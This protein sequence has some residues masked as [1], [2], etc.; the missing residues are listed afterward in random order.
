MSTTPGPPSEAASDPAARPAAGWFPDP[1]GGPALRWWDGERWTEHLSAMPPGGG[2]QKTSGFAIAALVFGI[3]GGPLF[4]LIF[5]FV[6]R[7]QIKDSEGKLG[8][9]GLATAGIVLGF[10]WI[11]IYA[12]ILVLVLT[13][14]FDEKV[15]ADRYTGEEQEVAAVVDQ[16]EEASDAERFDEICFELFTPEWAALVEQGSGM[17]CQQVF[18]DE[19]GGAMQVPITIES[20]EV[21]GATATAR[22]DEGGVPVTFE[23]IDDGGRWRI[24]E[25]R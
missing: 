10:A 4:A 9:R 19:V 8:G 16:F 25:L 11:A 17:T 5:G 14:V 3:I 13:G 2:G 18:E 1:G 24:N 7:N 6:A 22:T 23:M 21:N 15:N 12:V 20:L